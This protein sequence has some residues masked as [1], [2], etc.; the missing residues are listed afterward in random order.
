LGGKFQLMIFI[1]L[2][3]GVPMV[4]HSLAGETGDGR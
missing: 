4:A 1:S 3:K 2:R